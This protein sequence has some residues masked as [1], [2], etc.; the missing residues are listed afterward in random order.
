[1]L[2]EAGAGEVEPGSWMAPLAG[3]VLEVAHSR[4]LV[5]VVGH[6]VVARGACGERTDPLRPGLLAAMQW[7]DR[8]KEAVQRRVCQQQSS[9]LRSSTKLDERSSMMHWLREILH[10]QQPVARKR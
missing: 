6:A 3:V 9:V 5:G 10:S 7:L 1:M 8:R 4:T 2:V